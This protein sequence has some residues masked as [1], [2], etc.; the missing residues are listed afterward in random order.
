VIPWHEAARVAGPLIQ[1]KALAFAERHR[2]AFLVSRANGERETEV[3][4]VRKA[5][6]AGADE[7]PARLRVVLLGLGTV[8]R[9]VYDRLVALRGRFELA[10][11]VVRRPQRHAAVGLPAS[12]LTDDAKLAL[13]PDVDLVI[14]CWG[15]VEPAGSVIEA[16]LAKGKTVV[17]ANKAA[18]AAYWPEFASFAQ[19]PDRRLW[20]SAAAGGAV[21][22]LETLSHLDKY[23]RELRGVINGTS[24][25]VLDSMAAGDSLEGAVRAAQ[26][27]GFAEADPRR[28]LSGFD[29]ADKLSLLAQAAFGVHVP[30]AESATRG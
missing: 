18:V 26:V 28:D 29:T 2:V 24:N 25:R 9:G 10:G 11:V 4:G 7:T 21:P 16:A 23:V 30:T 22:M 12:L 14:E 13:R 27:A 15:G 1:P 6:W 3:A 20:F 5:R 8:G 19:E 17:T